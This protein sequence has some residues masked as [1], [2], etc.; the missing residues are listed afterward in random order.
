MPDFVSNPLTELSV[1]SLSDTIVTEGK[2]LSLCD[3]GM[4]VQGS[5]VFSI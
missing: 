3:I 2:S 1:S 5:G 4:A